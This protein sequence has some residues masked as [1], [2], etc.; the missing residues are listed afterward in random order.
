MLPNFRRPFL[1][2]LQPRPMIKR[3]ANLAS[4][5]VAHTCFNLL[6]LPDYPT[7]EALEEKLR[8]ALPHCEGFELR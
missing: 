6:D 5:P 8:L 7:P 2:Q 1:V 3:V 4:L